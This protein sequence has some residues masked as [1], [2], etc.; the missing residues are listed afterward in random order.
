MTVV[1]VDSS[2][3]V[4]LL[5]EETHFRRLRSKLHKA[6]EVISAALLEAE[7]YSVVHR[8]GIDNNK[9]ALFVE[10][11]TL[12]IPDRSL[13]PEYN[14]IFSKGYCRGADAFHLACALYLDPSKKDLI[15]LTEDERQRHIAS[16]LGFKVS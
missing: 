11:I 7:I 8:E 5:L 6:E 3:V 1:Y 13:S 14:L 10:P 12:I 15:F 16:Q 9:A 2:V 4:S